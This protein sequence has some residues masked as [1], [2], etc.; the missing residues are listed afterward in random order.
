MLQAVGVEDAGAAE[1]RSTFLDILRQAHAGLAQALA[2]RLKGEVTAAQGS[3]SPAD[4]FPEAKW[5]AAVLTL[6]GGEATLHLGLEAAL[7]EAVRAAE[8]ESAAAPSPRAPEK[9]PKHPPLGNSKTFPLLLEVELPV[10]VS[11]GRAN[12]PLKDVLKLTTGSIVELNR[13]VSEPVDI[14]VNNCVIARGEVVV[15]EGN[16]GVRIQEVIDRQDRLRT[17]Q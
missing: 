17:V 15:V 2:G 11:F 1:R 8:S 12:I 4:E 7:I 9:Q 5:Y 10:A 13:A 3:E 16:F 14:I 6:P